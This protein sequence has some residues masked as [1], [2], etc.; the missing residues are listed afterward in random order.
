MEKIPLDFILMATVLYTM[1]SGYKRGFYRE[2]LIAIA[3][4]PYMAAMFYLFNEFIQGEYTFDSVLYKFSALSG[5]Y[6]AY[7]FVI[8]GSA[9][10]LKWQLE[11]FDSTII[12]TGKTAAAFI[13]G[14][15]TVYF[16]LLCLIAFNVHIHNDEMLEKSKLAMAGQPVALK[17]QDH[18]LSNGY[19]NNEV[20]VYSE[21]ANG[22]FDAAGR[23]EHPLI[24]QVKNSDRFK[25]IESKIDKA[26]MQRQVQD[27]MN[28]HGY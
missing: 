11:S 25:E 20:T 15:R 6:L 2:F 22:T 1:Y 8:W 16:C 26:K 12:Y 10:A 19:I 3:Y 5:F 23:Y 9:K 27:L 4:V 18:L 24:K 13:S 7:L 17:I 14:A 21:A 28:S